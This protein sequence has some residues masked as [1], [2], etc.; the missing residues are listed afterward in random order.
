MTVVAVG[1]AAIAAQAQGTGDGRVTSEVWGRAYNATHANSNKTVAK[2]DSWQV[3]FAKKMEREQVR[4][5][6][7]IAKAEKAKEQ[8]QKAE[9]EN[10]QAAAKPATA[11][12]GAPYYYYGREGKVMALSDALSGENA[13]QA[14]PAKRARPAKKVK[15][16]KKSDGNWFTR[17][18]GFAKYENE[19]EEEWMSRLTAM[20]MK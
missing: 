12:G 20:A 16:E 3:S 13:K 4:L 11:N 14:K 15:A 19:T 6:Q 18:M 9:E 8:A 1:L 7:Q 5:A 2:K 10:A 17:L